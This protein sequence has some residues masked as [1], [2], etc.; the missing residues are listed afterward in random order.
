MCSVDM[1]SELFQLNVIVV[2]KNDKRELTD[3]KLLTQGLPL[4]SS[5]LSYNITATRNGPRG[6]SGE[7]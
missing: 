4:R 2:Y 3:L 5:L 6:Q 7:R 1:K